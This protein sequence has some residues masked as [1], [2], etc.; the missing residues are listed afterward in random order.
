MNLT[1]HVKWIT[2][3]LSILFMLSLWRFCGTPIICVL[4]PLCILIGLVAALQIELFC[5]S[6]I[7]GVPTPPLWY[8]LT[9]VGVKTL[10]TLVVL[11]LWVLLVVL[12][13]TV[14]IKMYTESG[15]GVAITFAAVIASL[16]YRF[17][18]HITFTRVDDD[19][20]GEKQP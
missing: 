8:K 6:H 14:A 10:L 15:E 11:Q 1:N 19:K 12:F 16:V 17:K 2:V 13:T 18:T 9:P 4:I 5:E 3:S 20:E 7:K